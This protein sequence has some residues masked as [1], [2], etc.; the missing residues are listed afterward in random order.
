MYRVFVTRRFKRKLRR[1]NAR[2]LDIALLEKAVG[3]LQAEGALPASY[4]PHKLKGRY[5]GCWECHIQPDWLLIWQM[6]AALITLM[7][8]GTHSDLF[9]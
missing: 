5:H 3:I 6:D 7:D 8:T 9:G 4:A 2:G 1:C